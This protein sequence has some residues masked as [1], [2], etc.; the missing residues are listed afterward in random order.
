VYACDVSA[1]MLDH[2]HM[3]AV[4]EGWSDRTGLF[5][6]DVCD[7]PLGD[8]AVDSAFAGWVVGHFADFHPTS[9]LHTQPAPWRS[10]G[11]S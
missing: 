2:A 7:I 3:A 10:S 8:G 11:G 4:A 6:G 9:W 5:L 1:A